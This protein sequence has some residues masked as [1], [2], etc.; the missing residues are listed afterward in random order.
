MTASAVASRYANALADVVT[1]PAAPLE[2]Q[3]ALRELRAFESVFHDSA[4]LRNA[5]VTPSI[6]PS[7]KKA[8]IARLAGL[9]Q[10]SR[11]ARN[12]LFIL[13]DHRR[14]GGLSEIIQS[15]ED[16][17][18]Q[19]M[20][21]ARAEIVSAGD[22]NETQRNALAADLER[23]TGKRLRMRFAVDPALIGGLTA[24]VASTVYDGSVRGQLHALERRLSAEE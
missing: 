24:R 10:L 11:I 2:P 6:A 1:A 19:R 14:I 8:V 21:F 16:V 7:R 13:I 15:L 23:V 12:F 9:L 18:D 4:D 22:L 5:L 3:T 20:G 17:L